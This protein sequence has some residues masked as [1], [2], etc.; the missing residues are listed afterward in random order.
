MRVGHTFGFAGI[1]VMFV[2]LPAFAVDSDNLQ[3]RTNKQRWEV[4]ARVQGVTANP[5]LDN[6]YDDHESVNGFTVGPVLQRRSP[7]GNTRYIIG[8][9]YTKTEPEDGPWLEADDDPVEAEYTEF[10]N[11]SIISA[12]FMAGHVFRKGPFGFFFGGGLGVSVTSGTITSYE[13]DGNG[14]KLAGSAPD[15]KNVPKITPVPLVPLFQAGP[16]MELGRVGTISL[17]VG[18]HH[19]LYAG[20]GLTTALPF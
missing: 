11:F 18:F 17:N 4:G 13:T 12:N 6:F 19:G 1:A 5:I 8:V 10:W 2:S 9:D 15:E 16:Q 3:D 14:N 7:D 20:V